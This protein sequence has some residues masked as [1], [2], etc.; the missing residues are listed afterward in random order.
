MKRLAATGHYPNGE[1]PLMEHDEAIRQ[2]ATERYLLDEL[3]PELRDQFEEH[4]FAC[5]DCALDLQSA[6]LLI[7]QSKVILAEGPAV[8]PVQ[9]PVSSPASTGWFSWLRPAFAAPVLALLLAVVVYQ[10]RANSRLQQAV[11]SPQ[12][13]AS[14]VVNLNVRGTEPI[15][16]P[17]HVGQAFGLTLNVPA[18]SGYSYYKLDLYSSQGRLEWSR[19]IAASGSDALSL[20]IPGSG[21]E[22]GTLA[23]H[24]IAPGGESVNLGRFQIELQ[25]EK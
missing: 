23:V 8:F 6:V 11:N 25:P 20:Y 10:N 9:A 16:V 13:M 14:A 1:G 12:I 7:E 22:P 2:K 18:E 19:T 15:P 5:Q 3:S 17:A 24:G 21:D 4:L